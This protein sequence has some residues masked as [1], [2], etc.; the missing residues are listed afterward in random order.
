MGRSRLSQARLRPPRVPR[1]AIE[2]PDVV[3]ELVQ[4]LDGTLVTVVAGAGGPSSVTKSSAIAA[5]ERDSQRYSV[6][7]WRYELREV[8]TWTEVLS[9]QR[10][11]P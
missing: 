4:A 1:G 7:P 5:G 8:A 9:Q 3:A 6:C 10:S 2:R 11:H